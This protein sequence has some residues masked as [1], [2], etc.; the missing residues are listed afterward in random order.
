MGLL[1]GEHLGSGRINNRMRLGYCLDDSCCHK[2][3][4]DPGMGL[5]VDQCQPAVCVKGLL[6]AGSCLRYEYI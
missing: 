2:L 3:V 1:P 5:E 6:G 4:C